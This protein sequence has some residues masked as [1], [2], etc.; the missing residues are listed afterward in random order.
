M[1]G[2]D[3]S[4]QGFVSGEN[5]WWASKPEGLQSLCGTPCL[6]ALTQGVPPVLSLPFGNVNPRRALFCFSALLPYLGCLVAVCNVFGSVSLILHGQTSTPLKPQGE[7]AL[8]SQLAGNLV[9]G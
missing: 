9:L 5:R 8:I 7:V 4:L 2:P 1:H 6:T 3:P